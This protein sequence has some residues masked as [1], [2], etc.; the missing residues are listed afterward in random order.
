M[1]VLHLHLEHGVVDG[2]CARLLTVSDALLARAVEV[3]E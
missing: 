2:E 1:K 3:I